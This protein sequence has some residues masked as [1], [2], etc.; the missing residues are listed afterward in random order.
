MSTIEAI[1]R[2]INKDLVPQF[3]EKLRASLAAQDKEWLIEQIIRLTLDKYSLEEMDRQ[4]FHE[5]EHHKR[6]ERAER[7]KAL[8]L[9]VE[10]LGEFIHQYK[11][12]GR[13]DLVQKSLLSADA[14]AKGRELITDRFRSAEGAR[15]LQ[16]AK[17]MLYGL[18]FGDETMN[19]RFHRTQRQLLTLT[20]PRMKSDPL[21]FMK[22]TTELSA[23]GK[24]QDSTGQAGERRADNVVLEIEYGEIDGN[25]IAEGIVTAL[26]L[27]NHLEINEEV[28]YGRIEKVERSTLI[29]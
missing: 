27:I 23:Q 21:D 13:E 29:S 7:V 1:L 16:Y 11:D 26:R 8:Q 24:W 18:L 19:A 28:L 2:K 25:Q 22:A 4:H 6:Q 15:L 5:E 14:V 20:V 10:K 12:Y 9:D 17:D 3:E